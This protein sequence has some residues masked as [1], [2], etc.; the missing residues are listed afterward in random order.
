MKSKRT[1][2]L[3]GEHKILF[4]KSKLSGEG[5]LQNG[6]H[7]GPWKFY[8]QNGA[9]KAIGEYRNGELDALFL[10]N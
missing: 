3:N 8:Y 9:L 5:H 1:E 2:K 7:H 10:N 6:K 4:A